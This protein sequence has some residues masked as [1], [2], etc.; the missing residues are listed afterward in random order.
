M[1]IGAIT[2]RIDVAEVLLLVFFAFFAGLIFYLRREDRREGYPLVSEGSD[3]P[4]DH[5]FIWIP[6]PKTF[7][8]A[9]GRKI[10][11]PN[12]KSDTRTL[13]AVPGE[14]WLGAPLRPVGD[15][16]LA[17]VGPGSYAERMD[18]ADVT[19][20]GH[21]RIVPLRASAG[22]VIE[23][24]DPD[25]RGMSVIGGDGKAAG[26][27]T[28]V[29][30]DRSE[31]LIRYLEVGLHASTKRVLVPMTFCIVKSGQRSIVVDAIAA[32]QFA[33]VPQL[34]SPDTVTL[35]E[36]DRICGYYGGGTLYATAARQEP[37]L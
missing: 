15:P 35:L 3:A 10:L 21:P 32:G 24:R 19:F 5:G 27:V 8:L 25:P 26:D 4:K 34:K 12:G 18:I 2:S 23:A 30:V 7:V 20:E 14:P 29:W 13:K 22:F 36:E 9:D 1:E 17:N 31:C 11:A 37:L 16:M 28:D 6:G 33:D